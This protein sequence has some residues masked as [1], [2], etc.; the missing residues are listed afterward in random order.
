[1]SKL[2]EYPSRRIAS[3][4]SESGS[5]GFALDVPRGRATISRGVG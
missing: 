4:D 3:G 2:R 1:M 5:N